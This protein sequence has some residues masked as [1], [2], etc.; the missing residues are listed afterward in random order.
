MNWPIL[1]KYEM[2]YVISYDV[3]TCLFINF[4]QVY[5]NF[6]VVY[7]YSAFVFIVYI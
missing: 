5:A 7:F 6:R 3:H 2:S 1:C 4:Y